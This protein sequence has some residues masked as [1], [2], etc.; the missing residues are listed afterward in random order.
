MIFR[1]SDRAIFNRQE[2]FAI[3]PE[4]RRPV[5]NRQPRSAWRSVYRQPGDTFPLPQIVA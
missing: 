5:V 3:R 2:T 4:P 1:E